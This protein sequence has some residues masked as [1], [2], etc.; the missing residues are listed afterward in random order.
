[1]RRIINNWYNVSVILAV[2]SAIMIFAVDDL[3]QKL[4]LGSIAILFLHFYEEFGFP[5]GFAWMGVRILLGSKEMNSEKWNCNNLNSMFGNWG[6]LILVYALPLLVEVK[7]LVL[8]AMIFSLMELIMHLILFNVK[9][10]TIYNP[11]LITGAFGLVPIAIYYFLN[12]YDGNLYEWSDFLRAIVWNVFVFWFSFRSPLYW[13][14]GRLRGYKLTPQT[15]YGI[16]YVNSH[17]L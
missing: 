5:G 2:V 1:M 17:K 13:G 8:A 6:F 16:G 7:F 10:K 11:G 9:I 3:T 14:L 4:L 15:A 12:V